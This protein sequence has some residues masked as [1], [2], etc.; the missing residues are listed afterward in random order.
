MPKMIADIHDSLIENYLKNGI[1]KDNGILSVIYKDAENCF[2]KASL[3]VRNLYDM[4]HKFCVF[5]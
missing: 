3:M 2:N 5:R 1:Y 4:I